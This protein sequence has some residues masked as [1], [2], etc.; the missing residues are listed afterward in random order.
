MSLPVN[1]DSIPEEMKALNNWV[2]WKYEDRKDS[3]GNVKK[4]KVPYQVNGRK[5]ESTNKD[6]WGSFE[7]IIKTLKRY[8]R[9]D[10]I[11]FVFSQDSGIMGL[12]F[13]HVKDIENGEWD[14]EAQKEI[15]SLNSYT[16]ISPSGT[17]AHVIVKGTVPLTPDE[18]KAGKTGKKN[19]DTGREMYHSGRFF[20]ITGDL[21]EDSAKKIN[22]AQRAV[23][24]LYYKW[25]H[26]R[27]K[28]KI[29][30]RENQPENKIKLSNTEIIEIASRAKNSATFKSLYSGSISGY[31]SQSEA[32]LALCSIFAFY[33]QDET[34][35]D[36]LLRGSG[37]YRDKW[38]RDDYRHDTINKALQGVTETYNPERK[39]DRK[40]KSDDGEPEKISVPF[41]V[42]ADRVLE[43]HHIFSMRDNRQIYL[44][45]NG[46]Y[47]SEGADA[48][49]DTEIRNL[50]NE[51]YE[52]YWN[53][54]NKGFP[55]KHIPK[56]TT[57]YVNEVLAYIRAYT[58][59]TRESIEKD[60]GNYINLANGLF[61]LD[62]WKLEPHNPKI[63]TIRQN[64]V[65][66]NEA[67][68]CPQINKFLKD[69]VAEPD[70]NLLCEIAGYCLTT[71]CSFQKAFMLYGVGS[72][73]KSVFLALLESLVGKENTS[74][75][76]LQ[77]LEFDKYRIAKLYGKLV[78]ICGD[79]PDTKMHKS[80]VFKKLTSGLD[81]I[82]GENKYQDPFVFR[83]T[84]KLVFSA[85]VLPEGKKDKAYYRRWHLIQF[86]NNFEG[87]N[88]DK[89]LIKK[90]QDPEELSGFLNLALRGLKRLKENE[91]FSND[92]TTED[93]Q[94]E[95]E[96]N[97]NPIAAFMD[98]CTKG[99][100]DDID[101]IVLYSTYT[102]WAD[103]NNKK[104]TAYNQWGKE[105]KK[106]GFEN[107]RENV[108]GGNCNKKV[109]YWSNIEIIQEAQDR[110]NWKKDEQACPNFST[111]QDSEKTQLGQAGQA[112]PL[113]QTC[114]TKKPYCQSCVFNTVEDG[115]KEK[116]GEYEKNSLTY[117]SEACPNVGFSGIRRDRTGSNDTV[118]FVPVLE[119]KTIISEQFEDEDCLK[120]LEY[121]GSFRRDLK[122]LVCNQYNCVVESIPALLSHFNRQNP[123][124]RQVLGDAVLIEEAEKL[125]KWGWH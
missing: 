110:L 52:E 56:A 62:T 75:E 42:V 16:E 67:A 92:K 64:P 59:I 57:K 91:K 107:F 97:S 1:I 50:H 11:G 54:I 25:F 8:T 4:T 73:G 122:T 72:N 45:I 102:L 81:L 65:Y 77:K 84:A 29:T 89:D 90:L 53:Y 20:T 32:D 23:N 13:D 37:L 101:A 111:S 14:Q 47:K 88:D 113:P 43:N 51:I 36:N 27:D 66:Y 9:Y 12:D 96:F 19:Q 22:Q 41:D 105:L 34:Q 10:G 68:E 28:K 117:N 79:I 93:T 38:E 3:K 78:N 46:V 48:I 125:K 85:N 112:L 115:S 31:G 7:N 39:R 24:A 121:I 119:Q 71:D 74:A 87:K 61:N 82:D 123:G 63:K 80:E 124:Y 5:A 98:E 35:I 83:N 114:L 58:H 44:Y 116:N 104:T 95:Y 86:P 120:K 94:K 99:S 76:S 6:T 106:L 70:I 100:Q 33:T 15:L 40:R 49:L 55:L 118:D 18:I 60:Q 103:T 26:E 69:V 17:G 21:T 109:T 2:L 30:V 108:P